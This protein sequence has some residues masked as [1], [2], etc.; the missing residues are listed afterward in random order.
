[1]RQFTPQNFL[2][3]GDSVLRGRR[4]YPAAHGTFGESSEAVRVLCQC[5]YGAIQ[6]Q[7]ILSLT[8]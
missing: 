3:V 4:P 8:A 7:G 5:L 6:S 2:S 1:M